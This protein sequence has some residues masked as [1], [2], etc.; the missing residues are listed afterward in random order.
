MHKTFGYTYHFRN[1][2]LLPFK[3]ND[4]FMQWNLFILQLFNNTAL[5]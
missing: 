4:S 5:N 3:T 1:K 2:S